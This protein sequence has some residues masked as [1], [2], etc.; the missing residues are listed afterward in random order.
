MKEEKG[1]HFYETRVA[2]ESLTTCAASWVLSDWLT[3]TNC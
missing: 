3:K 2:D 1:D